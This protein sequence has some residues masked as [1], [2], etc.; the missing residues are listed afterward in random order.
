MGWLSKRSNS[1]TLSLF[2]TLNQEERLQEIEH[3]PTCEITSWAE[4]TVEGGNRFSGYPRLYSKERLRTEVFLMPACVLQ[5][6]TA[7]PIT[8]PGVLIPED[9]IVSMIF[10][11]RKQ[12]TCYGLWEK[13]STFNGC[14]KK[15]RA[16][17]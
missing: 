9:K 2:L 7:T 1:R 8:G 11:D 5:G 10:F 13:L 15:Q 16:R 3:V 4:V 17:K 6:M 12:S 14:D